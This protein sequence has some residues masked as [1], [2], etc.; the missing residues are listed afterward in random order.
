MTGIVSKDVW[1]RLEK[2]LSTERLSSFKQ[3]GDTDHDT[4]VARYLWN[5]ALCES[6]YPMLNSVEIAARNRLDLAI[7]K[8]LGNK[9]I[10]NA[11]LLSGAE[12][13]KIDE[14]KNSLA[15]RGK[16]APT[17]SEL[18]AELSFGFWVNL[19]NKYYERPDRLWPRFSNDVMSGAPKPARLRAVFLQRM[20]E[21][22][23]LRNRA[24]HH[25]PLWYWQ[26][27]RDQHQRGCE[28][29]LWLSPESAD[30]LSLVNRFEEVY[31]RGFDAYECLVEGGWICPVHN[32][33]CRYMR[34]GQCTDV[35]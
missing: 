25:E 23:Q 3:Q 12:I 22:K 18:V 5:A 27:L 21:M 4:A 35:A 8:R 24:F 32:A 6:L 7:T 10:E 33:G 28:L 26:D 20:S 9:W 11:Q 17:H 19:F 30:L 14:A 15:R 29:L 34:S 31:G 13:A 1:I 2:G 16:A